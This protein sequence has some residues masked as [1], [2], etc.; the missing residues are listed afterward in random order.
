MKLD[1]GFIKE[2][3]TIIEQQNSNSIK[4][5]DLMYRLGI[6]STN[7]VDAVFNQNLRDI[8]IGHIQLLLENSILSSSTKNGGFAQTKQ[9]YIFGNATYNITMSGYQFLDALKNDTIFNKIKDYAL[10]VAINIATQELTQGI[11]PNIIN[12]VK[13]I[14]S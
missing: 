5:Y 9:G 10:P 12:S 6:M 4:N 1:Y 3:L 11:I 7:D 13:N 8:Y 14:I 2:I